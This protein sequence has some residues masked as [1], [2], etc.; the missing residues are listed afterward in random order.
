M[1]RSVLQQHLI[2]PKNF[3]LNLGQQS[4]LI[5]HTIENWGAPGQCNFKIKTQNR[6]FFGLSVVVVDLTN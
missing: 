6:V 1:Y 3:T 5:V 2:V 4:D